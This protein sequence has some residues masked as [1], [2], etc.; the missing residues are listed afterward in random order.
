MKNAVWEK[1]LKTC[2]D[3]KRGK[4]FYGLLAAT[5]AG[6]ALMKYS[7]EHARLLCAL[8]SGS[9][10]LSTL[11][12]KRPEWLD[13]LAP[14]MLQHPRRKQGLS[15]EM[16]AWL[17]PALETADYAGAMRHLREFKQREM[18]R[19]A[20]RDLGG[21]GE[22]SEIIQEISAV[23]DV[24]L[25]GV[26][27]TCHSQLIARYGR[28]YHQDPHGRWQPTVGCVLGRSEERRVGKGVSLGWGGVV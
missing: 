16:T 21:I 22:V 15:K 6:S 4:H 7:A 20:A 18:L 9:Q 23:A 5:A 25:D 26:W 12:V 10:A 19:I 24:C 17:T 14:E 13:V 3:P 11:L 8:F 1:A 27:R 28:P 2:A